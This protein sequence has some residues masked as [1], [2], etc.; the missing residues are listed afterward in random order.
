MR[1]ILEINPTDNP[2]VAEKNIDLSIYD[3]TKPDLPAD[4]R[5]ISRFNCITKSTESRSEIMEML[6]IAKE[7]SS[8]MG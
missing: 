8:K 6:K 1:P 5:R 4:L 3:I 2:D 7:S